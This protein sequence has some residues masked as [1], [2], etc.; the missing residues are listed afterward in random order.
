MSFERSLTAG[1]EKGKT[2]DFVAQEL[3]REINTVGAKSSDFQISNNVIIIK[4]EIEKIREQL[5]NIE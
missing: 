5:K 4:G 3:I 1:G 2:L